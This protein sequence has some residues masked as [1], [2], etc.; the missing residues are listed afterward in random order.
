M[1]F[2]HEMGQVH[3]I[4]VYNYPIPTQPI[5]KLP[6]P[7]LHQPGLQPVQLFEWF[8][9]HCCWS[10]GRSV[11]E[12]VNATLKGIGMVGGGLVGLLPPSIQIP[13]CNFRKELC[14]CCNEIMNGGEL[15]AD[16]RG[17]IRL[18]LINLTC[19]Q[20]AG[21][22]MPAVKGPVN[23]FIYIRRWISLRFSWQCVW[24]RVELLGGGWWELGV[25]RGGRKR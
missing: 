6:T 19:S 11:D 23:K 9:I 5:Y 10:V 18:K 3:Q 1:V 15:Q 24:T 7:L 17:E 4:P 8:V 12:A 20:C 2:G 13:K 25:Q 21:Q 22:L 14:Q 16:R